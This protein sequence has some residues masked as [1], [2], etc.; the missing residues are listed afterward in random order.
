[1]RR[2]LL[3]CSLL[4]TSLLFASCGEQGTTNTANKP[5]NTTNNASTTTTAAN[6]EAEIKKIMADL[7]AA[8]AKND[9]EAASKFYSEDYHLITPQ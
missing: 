1:M 7:A 9:A 5:A 4:T 8:L 2:T 6:H 3:S